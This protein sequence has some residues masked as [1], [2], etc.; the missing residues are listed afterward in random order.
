MVIQFRQNR[1]NIAKCFTSACNDKKSIFPL[2]ITKVRLF[3]LQ[4]MYY[5]LPVGACIKKSDS[6]S[7]MIF[8]W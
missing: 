8:D 6:V 5:H 7:F 4:L 1:G 3:L 2:H